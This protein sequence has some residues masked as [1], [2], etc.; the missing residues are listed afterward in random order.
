VTLVSTE[1]LAGALTSPDLRV[2]DGSWHLPAMKRD[3]HA[4]FLGA[5]VPGAVFFDIDA[6]ADT[7]SPLPHMLPTADEFARAVGALGIGT[8][9]RV[10]VY[11]TG[12]VMSAARVWW[13]F[14][15]FGHDNVAVLDGGFRKWTREG[16]PVEA[17][18]PGPRP[19]TFHARHRPELVRDLERMRA[20]VT[21]KAEQVADARPRGRFLGT[22]PEPRPGL[23]SG[24]IPGSVH[25]PPDRLYRPDGTMLPPDEI[26]RAAAAAGLDLGRPIVTTCG[27]GVAASTV[28]LALHLIGY[29]DVAVYDGSW[30]E[31]GGRD[32]T[33]VST[34]P[35]DPPPAP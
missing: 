33:P 21:A 22:E 9:D 15:V 23:R 30:T 35:E 2:V 13:T 10:V 5:H 18:A 32:D 25:L 3:P 4:E 24:H 16:R 19:R 17:G 34:G 6:V 20:N 14:R 31:W 26:R 29:P 12:G 11:D 7:G 8:G 1:W 27:S 28:A